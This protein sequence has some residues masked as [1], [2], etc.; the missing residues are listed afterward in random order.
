MNLPRY[1]AH[2]PCIAA[3]FESPLLFL[4]AVFVL[5]VIFVLKKNLLTAKYQIPKGR[6]FVFRFQVFGFRL[7]VFVGFRGEMK[8]ENIRTL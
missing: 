3:Y 5:F 8:G 4:F 2:R 6:P 7:P 1:G